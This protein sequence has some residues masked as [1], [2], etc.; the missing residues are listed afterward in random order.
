[1][2]FQEY[3][4]FVASPE[5]EV[6][7][8]QRDSPFSQIPLPIQTVTVTK[9]WDINALIWLAWGYTED[10]WESEEKITEFLNFH[11][12]VPLASLLQTMCKPEIIQTFLFPFLN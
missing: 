1:M 7:E 12:S 8:N 2:F 4:L 6:L 11:S 9:D 3:Y 5:I 10:Q